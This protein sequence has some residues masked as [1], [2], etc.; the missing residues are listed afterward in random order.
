MSN[1][2]YSNLYGHRKYS[3]LPLKCQKNIY[4]IGKSLKSG[5]LTKKQT[6]EFR[7]HISVIP[8]SSLPRAAEEIKD[9]ANLYRTFETN[10][11]ET[12]VVSRFRSFWKNRVSLKPKPQLI[13][14]NGWIFIFHGDGHLRQKAL[15]TLISK[16]VSP[17]EFVAIVYR[18]NDW[19]ENIRREASEY[20]KLRFPETSSDIIA[21]S[22]FFLLEQAEYLTRWDEESKGILDEALYRPDVLNSLKDKFLKIRSGRI[23]YIFSQLL[24]MPDFD[25]HLLDIALKSKLP[26]VRAVAF[27][28]LINKR[29]RW[30]SGYKKQWINKI[31]NLQRR[32]RLYETRD[33]E[34]SFDIDELLML[35]AN[36]RSAVV[37]K[38]AATSIINLTEN[39]S[40]QMYE[41]AKI[42]SSDKSAKV[43]TRAEFF[44]KNFNKSS[45]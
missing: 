27:D 44:L 13:P 39:K 45:P 7:N 34:H 1:K 10:K 23:A 22:A 14:E 2:K 16:P 9:I 11:Y 28:A 41:I 37:R 31:Y 18:L 26:Q 42:L 8:P 25:C 24:K 33:I 3:V 30:P 35:S 21:E 5:L 29:A 40:I 6:D 20:A 15:Q 38:I 12:R 17:F 32:Q 4:K 43:R 36:D 19:V